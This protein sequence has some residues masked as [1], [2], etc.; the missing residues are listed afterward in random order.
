MICGGKRDEDTCQ[1]DSGGPLITI[2]D[3]SQNGERE[4]TLFGVTSWGYG[5]GQ[6]GKP[7]VYAEVADY[8]PF[9]KTYL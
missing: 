7:G 8:L 1:G 3:N 5:C 2:V 9:I 4:Y 6:Q